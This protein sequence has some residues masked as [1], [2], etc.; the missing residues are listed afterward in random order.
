MKTIETLDIGEVASLLFFTRAAAEADQAL[1][2]SR[3][4]AWAAS[5]GLGALRNPVS[6]A[7]PGNF[8]NC[9]SGGFEFV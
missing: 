9:G 1:A 2:S 8:L 6:R 5:F 4:A 3:Q 7:F